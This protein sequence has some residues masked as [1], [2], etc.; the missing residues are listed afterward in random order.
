MNERE[1]LHVFKRYRQRQIIVTETPK[2]LVIQSLSH[3][4]GLVPSLYRHPR[5]KFIVPISYVQGVPMFFHD[6]DRSLIEGKE[7]QHYLVHPTLDGVHRTSTYYTDEPLERRYIRIGASSPTV[8]SLID[9]VIPMTEEHVQNTITRFSK[10]DRRS[11]TLFKKYTEHLIMQGA[12]FPTVLDYINKQYR[13]WIYRGYR[14]YEPSAPISIRRPIMVKNIRV[15]SKKYTGKYVHMTQNVHVT[16]DALLY[17]KN[18]LVEEPTFKRRDTYTNELLR[19]LTIDELLTENIKKDP[20][21][22]LD[23]YDIDDVKY[24]V[25]VIHEMSEDEIRDEKLRKDIAM[26]NYE[27]KH[28]KHTTI[29][30]DVGKKTISELLNIRIDSADDIPCIYFDL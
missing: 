23:I 3:K 16:Q 4:R 9:D 11:F 26:N 27:R 21:T 30:I 28:R 7:Q 25:S 24:T 20:E 1:Y 13:R 8:R 10:I 17:M 14:E 2:E 5:V 15:E 22:G 6:V 29:D 18:I 12:M 19:T